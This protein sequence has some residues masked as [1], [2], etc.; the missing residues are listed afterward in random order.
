MNQR[1]GTVAGRYEMGA[2]IGRG[3]MGTVH[4]AYDTR[5]ARDVAIKVLHAGPTVGHSDRDRFEREA[6]LGARISHPNV[7]AVYD[8]GEDDGELYIVMECLS[9]RTLADEIAAG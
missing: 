4:R 7:V 8:V 1:A 5:L 3:A 6:T 9:G 2:A